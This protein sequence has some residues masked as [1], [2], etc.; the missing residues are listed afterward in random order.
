MVQCTFVP[1]TS[2]REID[3]V[4]A[5]EEASFTNP[6]THE[7][8]LAEFENRGVAFCY[9]A[10]NSEGRA[11][12]FCSFWKVAD[13]LH[14][15]NVAVLP[16]ERRAGVATALLAHVLQEGA[17]LGAAR[18]TLEVRESNGAARRLYEKMGFSVAGIRQGYYT[19]PDEAAIILWRHGFGDSSA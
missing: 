14:I 19:K 12:G 3:E 16:S 15:N 17:R 4:V 2:R 11:I 13:E 6:W 18:A 8:H 5:I 9:L 10:R 7:M 1:L